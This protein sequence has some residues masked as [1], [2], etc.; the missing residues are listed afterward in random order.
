[1]ARSTTGFDLSL[2][3]QNLVMCVQITDRL[4]NVT[5]YTEHDQVLAH[6]L[7]DGKGSINYQPEASFQRSATEARAGGRVGSADLI[8]MIDSAGITEDAIYAGLY[9][10]AL[11]KM[12][13]LDWTQPSAGRIY[14]EIGE[15]EE[16]H[17]EGG[18]L[19]V[20]MKSLLDRYNTT[21]IG[22]Y[23]EAVCIHSL[24]SMPEDIPP[25]FGKIGCQV[26]LNPPVFSSGL[27]VEARGET[28]AKPPDSAESPTAVNTVQPSVQNGRFFEAQNAGT[29]G[30]EPSW[31]TALGATTVS[32]G[33]TWIARQALRQTFDLL[34][35]TDQRTL[36]L[37]YTGDFDASWFQLGRCIG[38]DG[39]NAGLVR[40][41]KSISIESPSEM[42]I[43][44]W[45]GFPLPLEVGSPRDT[46][47]LVVG[48]DHLLPTCFE[49]FRNVDNNGAFA[50]FAPNT[51]E[52]FKIPKI[53]A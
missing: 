1:M 9:D 29:T 4:D 11:F 35:F 16:T 45:K 27:V 43:T 12:F 17:I 21:K 3:N 33:I 2:D 42:I 39:R 26:Q 23:Y 47:T 31:N 19:T 20:T 30:A 18:R 37:D 40:H 5:G 7:G 13:L 48:C 53:N 50:A 51:D 24:G 34:G 52:V 22:D 41:I 6:D 14:V 46:F 44:L 10:A 49:K 25:P 15:F 8:G 38:A 32:S 28:N 36:T